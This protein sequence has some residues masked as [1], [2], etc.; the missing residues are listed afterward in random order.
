MTEPTEPLGE[1]WVYLR[2]DWRGPLQR[3]DEPTI[4]GGERS[5]EQQI[6][7]YARELTLE[8]G[9]E[10]G[11]F[12]EYE[13]RNLESAVA[14]LRGQ[15]SLGVVGPL[16]SCRPNG[17]ER[18][19]ENLAIDLVRSMGRSAAIEALLDDI[20]ALKEVRSIVE[21][22]NRLWRAWAAAAGVPSS[23]LPEQEPREL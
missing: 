17:L 6:G 23:G 16:S 12:V 5:R 11:S 10:A 20:A 22:P 8:V 1:R 14:L 19:V 3:A 4:D 13:I 18:Q 15:P 21:E 9:S 7:N 2:P